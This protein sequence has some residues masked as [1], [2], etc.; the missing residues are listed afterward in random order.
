[1]E[2]YDR[3]VM[4]I[5]EFRCPECGALTEALVAVGTGSVACGTCGHEP[6]ER[7]LSAQ[8]ATMRLVKPPGEARRQEMRNAKLHA[9]TKARFKE[10]RRK[11]REQ[12]GQGG[13]PPG[14]A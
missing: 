2:G 12:R 10:S 13:K 1:M 8:A 11:A 5:Y 6:T 4:P 14:T 9:D 3:G 7:V